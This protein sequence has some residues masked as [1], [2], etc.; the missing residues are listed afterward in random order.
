MTAFLL[1]I[2]T[3]HVLQWL[4]M[5]DAHYFARRRRRH[6][7]EQRRPQ[8]KWPLLAMAVDVTAVVWAIWHLVKVV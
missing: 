3:V 4:S 7:I 6:M 8:A 2:L 1:F 5:L